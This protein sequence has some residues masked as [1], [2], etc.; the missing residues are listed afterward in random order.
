MG[1][2]T[3]LIAGIWLDDSSKSRNV[4]KRET[5]KAVRQK[6][7]FNV[8]MR[9]KEKNNYEDNAC[10]WDLLCYGGWEVQHT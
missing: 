8:G 6:E 2:K 1:A 3:E 5:R 10:G 7:L 4:L 9:Q